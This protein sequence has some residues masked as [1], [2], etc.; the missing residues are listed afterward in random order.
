MFGVRLAEAGLVPDA[1]VRAGIRRMLRERLREIAAEGPDSASRAQEAVRAAMRSGP[2]AVVP[3][4]ANQQHYEL[5][6]ALFEQVLGP[7]LKYSCGWW[8]GGVVDLARAESAMLALTLERAG[9]QDGMR[10][11]DL[12]CGW[13]SFSL[14]LARSHPRCR[15]VAVS[16][17]KL[18]REWILERAARRGVRNLEVVTA[19]MNAFEPEGR[20]DR[21]VS[22]EMFEHMRNWEALLARVARWLAPGGRLFVHVFCH[23]ERAYLYEDRG[24]GDWMARTFFS[25]GLM[26]SERLLEECA[27]DF[28]VEAR[29]RVNG[30]HYRWTSEAWLRNLDAARDA[31]RPAFERSY[32]R[33]DAGLAYRRWRLFFLACSELFGFRGGEEWFVSHARLAPRTEARA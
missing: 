12:G 8:P 28:A 31:L 29:W 18:Q 19:D 30:L 32:G 7:H 11:L 26:P 14:W 5:D 15:V 13:G 22:V 4:L 10:V 1:L 24:P 33:A 27:A 3:A 25:G 23:R 16:N 21:I 2:I 17:S 6:P 20:F 9:V